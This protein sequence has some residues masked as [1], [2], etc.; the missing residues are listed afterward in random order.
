MLTHSLPCLKQSRPT[1][2][3]ESLNKQLNIRKHLSLFAQRLEGI[4][5]NFWI[6]VPK[7][8]I[9]L[10]FLYIMSRSGHVIKQIVVSSRFAYM[11]LLYNPPSEKFLSLTFLIL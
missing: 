6:I 10:R 1:R 5:F 9:I 3:N 4:K 2:I 8:L 11:V 7:S